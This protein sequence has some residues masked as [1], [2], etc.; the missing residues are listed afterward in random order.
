MASAIL[1]Q[2]WEECTA[3]LSLQVLPVLY[4]NATRMIARPLSKPAAPLL[5]EDLNA[6]QVNA[7]IR[8]ESPFSV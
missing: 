2:L 3:T 4:M 1:R 6:G 5:T 8:I 7:G